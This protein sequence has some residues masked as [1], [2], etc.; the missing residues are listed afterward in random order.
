MFHFIIFTFRGSQDGKFAMARRLAL[1]TAKRGKIVVGSEIRDSISLLDVVYANQFEG[2]F[3]D[4]EV[5]ENTEENFYRGAPPIWLNFHISEQAESDGTGTS[6]I[7]RDGYDTL[8]QQIFK[9]RKGPGTSAIK[10]FYQQGSGAT[11]M[12]MQVLWKLRK[13]FR[14]AVLTGSTSDITKVAKEV[15]HLFTAGS[16]DSHNT[17]LLLL[18]DEFILDNLQDKIMEEIEKQEIDIDMP[19]VILLNCVRASDHIILKKEISYNVKQKFKRNE[20]KYVILK[21]NL[22]HTEEQNFNKKKEELSKRYG[23]KLKHFHG[24]NILQ[25][26]F[27]P[28]YIKTAC[29]VCKNIKKATRPLKTQLAAFLSLLNAYV[30]GSYLLES[31]CLDF[32]Q[33]EDPS[34]ED[35]SLEDR[36]KPFSDLIITFQQDMRSERKVCMAHPMIAQCCTEM[37]AEAGVTRS[38]TA[39]DLLTCLCR[40]DVPPCLQ[41]FIKDMLT[42]RETKEEEKTNNMQTHISRG[43]KRREEDQEDFSRLILHI[44]EMEDKKQSASVLK[45]ASNKFVKN[46]LFPQAL[47]RFY[48]KELKDYN[49]AEM[50]AKTAKERDDKKSFIYDTL[51]QVHKHH[52]KSKESSAKPREILQLATKAIEAFKEEERLAENELDTG[53]KEDGKTKV[54]RAF[55]TRGQFGY[56]QVC[57]LVYDLLVS[58]NETWRKVL[59][60]NVSMGSVLESLGDNKLFRFN[61]LINSLRDEVE[62]KFNFF[63]TYLTYSESVIKRDDASYV[64]KET[65]ECYKKYVGDSAPKHKEKSDE[66]IQK[67]K[68][69]LAATSAGVLSCLDRQYPVSELKKIATWWN[70]ICVSK[71]S[72]RHALAN[73]ILSNIM[74]INKNETPSCSDYH[75][76]FRQ[77]MPLSLRDAPELHMLALLICWPTD[78]EDTCVSNLSQL[79]TKLQRSYEHEYKKLFQSRYLR[80]LFFIGKGRGLSRNVHRWILET[81]WTKDVLQNSN[82]NWRNENIFKDPLVQERLL[83]VEGVVRNYRLYAT[84]GG[85]E[86]EVDVNRKVSLWKSGQVSFYLGFTISGPVAFGIQ[87]RTE[88]PSEKFELG[89]LGGK[90]SSDWIVLEPEVKRVDEVKTYSLQSEAGCYECR[91][92]ALRWAC[93]EKVSIRYQFCSWEENIRKPVCMDYMPAGPLLDITVTE[94]KVEETYLPHWIEYDSTMSDM[95]AVLHVDTCGDFVEQASEVTSSHVKLRQPIFHH[96]PGVMIWQ[97]LGIPVKV[98]YDALIF[99]QTEKEFLTLH[100]YLVPPDED[101]QEKVKR[102]E[103]SYGSVLIP[104]PGPKKSLQIQDHFFL[105]TDVDT[106]EISPTKLKLRYERRD[107]FEVFIR[108]AESDFRLKLESKQKKIIQEDAVWT[109]TIRK[110]D[111]QHSSTDHEQDQHFVVRHRIALIKRV[112]A[113]NDILDQLLDKELITDENYDAVSALPTTQEQM[114]KI[115]K[116]VIL[117]GRRGKDTLYEILKG[118]RSMRP[119]ILELEKSE[120]RRKT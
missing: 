116:F 112:S 10:L 115:L 89:A 1:S 3:I 50:W 28:D 25:T 12:A 101:I 57:N 95:F 100:V 105:T 85:V 36:M 109:C 13:N 102:N 118:M 34:H 113:T 39:R 104:K 114:R 68:Q 54:L 82:T 83:K 35:L 97:K 15:V 76:A 81:L 64:A 75:N 94:G 74:L 111:Y 5:V 24:F 60:K 53:M 78:D 11:T 37:M 90:D 86:I 69:K 79:I 88:G 40:D 6:F 17:V 42:K 63:D 106:S 31:Q 84:F 77:K 107:Y 47:A 2:Q 67:L 59:T 55:N 30:P 103:A 87:T 70:E 27:S 19:V 4:P 120:K 7:K 58:Q 33:H 41:G 96:D 21:K 18:N 14:C 45:V 44:E 48:Y 117:A 99:K 46:C 66:T 62:E 56:L 98:N 110:G 91:V 93:K 32:L 80:P 65:S 119:L 29:A 8:V 26:N 20:R 61:D 73:Y 16:R 22:S 108:N 38:D 43:P 49:K 23:E 9:R 52:L 72:T 71:D 92:S 51:G